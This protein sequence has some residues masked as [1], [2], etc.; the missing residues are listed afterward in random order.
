MLLEIKT[1]IYGEDQVV[2]RGGPENWG[3]GT[4]FYIEQCADNANVYSLSN[5][6]E[7]DI[8]LNFIL[9]NKDW[10]LKAIQQILT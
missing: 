4:D 8:Q 6:S 7:T 10:P 9:K 2:T 5:S 1:V 3:D